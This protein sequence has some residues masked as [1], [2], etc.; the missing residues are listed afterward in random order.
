MPWLLIFAIFVLFGTVFFH[1]IQFVNSC[2]LLC[3]IGGDKSLF[4]Q[5]PEIDISMF[6]GVGQEQS[7]NLR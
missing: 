5:L 3:N 7:G 2:T 4:Y 1:V 6:F